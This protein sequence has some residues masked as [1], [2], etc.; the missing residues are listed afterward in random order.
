M[1]T[2]IGTRISTKTSMKS[3]TTKNPYHIL[4]VSVS[5]D[6]AEIKRAYRDLARRHHPDKEGGSAEIMADLNRAYECL[7][8]SE[9]RAHFDLTGQDD[10]GT[11]L[12]VEARSLVMQAFS[13]GLQRDVGN[14]LTH[15]RDSIKRGIDVIENEQAKIKKQIEK[16]EQRREK[17]TLKEVKAARK[18]K[19]KRSQS[20]N[21]GA[22]AGLPKMNLFWML[23]DQQIA[24][25]RNHS[26]DL[27]HGMEV[28]RKAIEILDEYQSSEIEIASHWTEVRN[29]RIEFPGG[30][31]TFTK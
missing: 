31:S 28:T 20:H 23:I 9:R 8:D 29:F 30:A 10:F 13:D 19:E 4:G 25:M 11:P 7:S 5:A 15:A 16:L 21:D 27:D 22:D 26:I 6:E 1:M 17:I 3:P 12:E 2:R 24:G 18:K 14:V